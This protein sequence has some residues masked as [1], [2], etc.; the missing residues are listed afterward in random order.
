MRPSHNERAG[1]LCVIMPHAIDQECDD[2]QDVDG[3]RAAVVS[4]PPNTASVIEICRQGDASGG[5]I[6]EIRIAQLWRFR[7]P[8]RRARGVSC[9]RDNV[10]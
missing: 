9:M 6:G 3:C 2:P 8:G 5:M 7:K 1:V 10:P 4:V